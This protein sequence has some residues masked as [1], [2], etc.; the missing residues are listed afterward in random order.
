M[1]LAYIIWEDASDLDTTAWTTHEDDFVYTPVLCNQI[2]FVLYSGEEGVVVTQSYNS[3]G[4]VS[5]RTQIPKGMIKQIKW[6]DD[7]LLTSQ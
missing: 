4:E 6:L 2:G 7:V 5:N 1:K 3:N